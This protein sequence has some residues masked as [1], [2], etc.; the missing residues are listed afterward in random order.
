MSSN[1]ASTNEVLP[2]LRVGGVPEHFNLPWQLAADH[3]LFEQNG[4]RV[5]FHE[6]KQGTGE[7][8][9]QLKLGTVDIIVALTE[10]LIADICKGSQ[11]KLLGTYVESPLN[12]AIST[13]K[14]SKFN[15][16]D[17]L[18][19][20][21]IGISRFQSGS[22][23]MS[24]VLASQRGWQQSDLSYSVQN[25]F[26]N[27]RKSVNSEENSAF[28]WE[29]FMSKP[30]YDKQE[31]RYIGNIYTPWP[32]FLLASTSSVIQQNS[33]LIPRLFTALRAAIQIFRTDT[34]ILDKLCTQFSLQREDAA[35]WHSSVEITA[36]SGISE[37]TIETTISALI[38]AQILPSDFSI[39][40]TKL[41][42]ENLAELKADIKSMRLYNKP[43]LLTAIH[44]NLNYFKLNKGSLHYNQLLPYD[45][46]HYFGVEVLDLCGKSLNLAP[47]QRIIQIGSNLGGCS[48]YLAG[49]FGVEVLAVELQ[50]DLHSA[51]AELT[52]RCTDSKQENPVNKLVNHISGDFLRVSSHFSPNFYDSIV[53]WLT[54]LHFT[55]QQRVEL[56]ENSKNLLHSGGFFYLEDF[57]AVNLPSAKEK[58]ILQ[59]DVFCQYLPNLARY[60]AELEGSGMEIVRMDDLTR[61]WRDFTRRRSENWT[62]NKG[63]LVEIHGSE[64]FERLQFF[65][66]QITQLFEGGNV[67]GVRIVARKP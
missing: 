17:D 37:S 9:N 31:V 55:Q 49:K 16:I 34:S 43:E 22:H 36:S 5:E 25:N 51:A 39:E 29:Y 63:K 41:I 10:G 8:I 52:E 11:L 62:A 20:S 26:E 12:W 45:Q 18:K 15:C 32:C 35:L 19:G 42:A 38:A 4:L 24:C 66:R 50:S 48:R 47:K 30:Y 21:T 1:P 59:H 14:S 58:F 46:N 61:D 13:G 57:F 7:M 40:N 53:S 27:L 44:N 60:R 33:A 56:Y 6:I 67:G 28:M 3:N 23:L 65:Y 64:L 54:I 2:L